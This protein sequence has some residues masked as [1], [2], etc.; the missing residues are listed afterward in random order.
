V[1]TLTADLSNHTLQS[2]L[3]LLSEQAG[4]GKP[5]RIAIKA[6]AADGGESPSIYIMFAGPKTAVAKK[7]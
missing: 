5:L 7:K 3:R 1:Q 4:G 2:G 6:P